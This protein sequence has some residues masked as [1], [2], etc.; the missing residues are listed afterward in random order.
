MNPQIP[1]SAG[2]PLHFPGARPA[3]RTTI[4]DRLRGHLKTELAAPVIQTQDRSVSDI[5]RADGGAQ[6]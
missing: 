5:T 2:S 3:A 1:S 4:P 6:C